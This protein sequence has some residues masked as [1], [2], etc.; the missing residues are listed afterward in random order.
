M[1]AKAVKLPLQI[2]DAVKVAKETV[3]RSKQFN[4]VHSEK[5]GKRRKNDGQLPIEQPAQ[6]P[7]YICDRSSHQ[8]SSC[9]FKDPTCNYC[10]NRAILKPAFHIKKRGTKFV[11]AISAP[12]LNTVNRIK[13]KSHTTSADCTA[14]G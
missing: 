6:Q 5:S 4:K 9:R 8:P 10:T 14:K 2:E 13:H 11:K 1:F 7:Y 12:E 3:Y